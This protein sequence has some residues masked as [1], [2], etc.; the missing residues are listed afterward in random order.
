MS[1][2]NFFFGRMS[3]ESV[4]SKVLRVQ[5]SSS[6]D[7][8]SVHE[9]LNSHGTSFLKYTG[10]PGT[11]HLLQNYQLFMLKAVNIYTVFILLFI[12]LYLWFFLYVILLSFYKIEFIK[13]IFIISIRSI[14]PWK[15][16]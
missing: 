4:N 14:K 11:N 12:V 3:L 6:W 13:F 15:L 8:Y 2:M 10:V 7:T 5:N 1:K 16:I 9:I